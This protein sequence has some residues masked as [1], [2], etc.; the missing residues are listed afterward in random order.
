M[1][2]HCGALMEFRISKFEDEKN[3]MR[4]HHEAELEN[5]RNEL[6]QVSIERD[7]LSQSF[8]ESEKSKEALLRAS[9]HVGPGNC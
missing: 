7:S 2:N 4:R 8:K 9:S 6:E 1:Q 3:G 5:M